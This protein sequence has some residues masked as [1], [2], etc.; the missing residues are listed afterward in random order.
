MKSSI[1]VLGGTGPA[2]SALAVRYASLGHK[3]IIG[4]RD[5]SRAKEMAASLKSRHPNIELELSGA[6]NSL[7]ASANLVVVATPWDAA[8]DTVNSLRDYLGGKIIITMVNALYRQGK[9]LNALVLPRGSIAQHLD[10]ILPD[11]RIVGA[12]HHAPAKELGDIES[13]LDLDVMVCGDAVDAVSE[14]VDLV[15]EI[16]GSRGIKAGN[17]ASALAIEAMTAVLINVN[18]AYKTRSSI[19][20]SGIKV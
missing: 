7:A 4:S 19:K 10:A 2:G 16:P 11:A 15:N 12:F 13:P 17:L 1:G 14:V 5:S 18:L 3:V 9:S 20:L 6:E 8:E